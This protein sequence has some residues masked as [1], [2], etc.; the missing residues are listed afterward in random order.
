MATEMIKRILFVAMVFFYLVAGINH[1]VMPEFYY[2]LIPD[3]LP[4]KVLLNSSSGALEIL[5]AIG[6]LI[7]QT[8]RW[9]ATGIIL[10]LLVFIPS[11]IHFIQIGSCVNSSLCVPDWV[12]WIR[13]VVVHPVLIYWA[14][15]F[16][17]FNWSPV[18]YIEP[19]H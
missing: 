11:H 4:S 5:L 17:D 3:Y 1:F 15:S 7:P 19:V 14:W 6:M 13:L 18:S 12:A 8:R 10:L 16:R 9:S 2:P